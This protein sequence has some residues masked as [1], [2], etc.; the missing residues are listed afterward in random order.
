MYQRVMHCVKNSPVDGYL[1]LSEANR[2]LLSKKAGCCFPGA[3][4]VTGTE[5]FYATF[6]RNIEQLQ[7]AYPEYTV[8][9]GGFDEIA[10]ECG[11]HS[12]RTIGYESSSVSKMA[13]DEICVS[14]HGCDLIDMPGVVENIRAVKTPEE[15][16]LLQKAAKLSDCAYEEFL[17]HLKPGMTEKEARTVFDHILMKRGA[18]EFSFSTLLASG[19][20]TFLPHSAPTE[21]IIQRGDLILMDFGVVLNGYCSDTSR[22]VVMGKASQLQKERYQLV[23]DAQEEALAKIHAGMSC[24]EADQIARSKIS[25]QSPEGCYDHS[26]GHGIGVEV[27]ELPY[28]RPG[29]NSLL[30][31]NMAVS[32]EPGLYLKGWGGIRIE[33]VLIVKKERGLVLSSAPKSELLEL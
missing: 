9:R 6:S 12:I 19:P 22:T 29:N 18:D 10:K 1:I 30:A 14:F 32:V 3:V 2:Y 28:L 5:I 8:M 31:E 4:L 23:L 25:D 17:N 33:D 24:E 15:I 26:L 21:R 7:N 16:E 11:K 20:R 13:Y 27:H